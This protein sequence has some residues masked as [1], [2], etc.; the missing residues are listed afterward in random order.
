MHWATD[1]GLIHYN[2]DMRY[3]AVEEDHRINGVDGRV[4][5]W[6]Q[7]PKENDIECR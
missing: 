5:G 6:A 4:K 2:A 1:T 3:D 7:E